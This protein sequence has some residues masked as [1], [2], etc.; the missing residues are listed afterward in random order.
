MIHPVFSCFYC[1]IFQ[2]ERVTNGNS[3]IVPELQTADGL[4]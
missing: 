2:L 3:E 4:G 1:T